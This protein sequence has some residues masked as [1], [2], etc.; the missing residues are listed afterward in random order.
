MTSPPINRSFKGTQGTSF[1]P[2]LRSWNPNYGG[3]EG[4]TGDSGTMELYPKVSVS[5]TVQS[6]KGVFHG[7]V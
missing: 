4:K 6:T 7:I 5:G 3:V 1:Q 2:V